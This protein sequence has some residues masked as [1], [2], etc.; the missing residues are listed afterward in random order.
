MFFTAFDFNISRLFKLKTLQTYQIK[1]EIL[2]LNPAQE[3]RFKAFWLNLD[4]SFLG[5][6]SSCFSSNSDISTD[7]TEV[8]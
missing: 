2:T 1:I 5:L 8:E 7:R 3:L 4:I 6:G